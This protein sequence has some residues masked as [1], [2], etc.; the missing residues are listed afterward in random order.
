MHDHTSTDKFNDTVFGTLNFQPDDDPTKSN[1]LSTDPTGINVSTV[2]PTVTII[3]STM[4]ISVFAI[5][6]TLF[7]TVIGVGG[8]IIVLTFSFITV[9]VLIRY[10]L[11]RKRKSH[12]FTTAATLQAHNAI[13][14]QG[15]M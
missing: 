15:M 14:T 11:R 6:G 1:V 13:Q 7:Y 4:K 8:G 2:V 9:C 3:D 10:S 12:T 5:G